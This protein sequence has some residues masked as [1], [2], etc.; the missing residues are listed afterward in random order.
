LWHQIAS[1]VY[2]LFEHKTTCPISLG[3]NKTDSSISQDKSLNRV[4][5][6]NRKLPVT[7]TKDFLI[8]NNRGFNNACRTMNNNIHKDFDQFN[9]KN[10]FE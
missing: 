7:R 5:T 9:K 1:M 10:C 6:H 2:S 3:W 4:T 8:V